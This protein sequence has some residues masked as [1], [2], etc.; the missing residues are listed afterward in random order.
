MRL[1]K[2]NVAYIHFSLERPTPI[3]TWSGIYLYKQVL[4]VLELNGI[5]VPH[6]KPK[7]FT[8]SPIYRVSGN[9]PQIV[10][11]GFLNSEELYAFRFS[12]YDD[13]IFRVVIESLL[14]SV[15]EG[16]KVVRIEQAE[17][18]IPALDTGKCFEDSLERLLLEIEVRYNPTIFRFYGYDVLYPS[19]LR[20]LHSTLR[21]YY[22]VTGINAVQ[23]FKNS[24]FTMEL[25]QSVV[26]VSQLSIG[27][28]RRGNERYVKAFH[29]YA[30]YLA[31]LRPSISE[32]FVDGLLR[33]AQ[34]MGVGK[35]KSLGF[36][37]IAKIAIVS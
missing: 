34:I 30:K 11:S 7:Y 33:L 35:N 17:H 12:T 23:C 29:G 26:K 10:F 21:Q 24:A 8:L 27:R 3:T 5:T 14:H 22:I 15:I 18:N 9:S 2:V 1:G 13:R 28:G 37:D 4:R 6:D 31:T 16:L 36:G 20:F 32:F 19:P 25:L